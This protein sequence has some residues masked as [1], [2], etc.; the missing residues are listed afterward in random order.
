MINRLNI[1]LFKVAHRR[2]PPLLCNLS[3]VILRQ[4]YVYVILW[5][6]VDIFKQMCEPLPGLTLCSLH[7]ANKS[8]KSYYDSHFDIGVLKY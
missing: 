7:V 4:Q 3:S 2:T 8:F 5:S 1:H 6:A